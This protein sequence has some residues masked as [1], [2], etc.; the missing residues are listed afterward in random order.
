MNEPKDKDP[1]SAMKDAYEKQMLE[2]KKE[3]KKNME[4]AEQKHLTQLEEI[5]NRVIT[6]ERNQTQPALRT[7]PTKPTWQRNPPN[8]EQSPPH[9]LEATKM[10]EQYKPFCR[11]CKDLHEEYSCYYAFYVQEH[12]FPEGCGPKAS[13]S[14]PEYINYVND[15]H[16]ISEES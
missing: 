11:A 4:E 16:D 9:Q 2:M 5:Q 3:M 13:S 15:M 8:H 6:M 10:V 14:E 7:F 12:G 1:I